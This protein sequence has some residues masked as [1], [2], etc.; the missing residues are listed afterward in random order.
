[1]NKKRLFS[2][3]VAELRDGTLDIELADAMTEVV[4]AVKE[5]GGKGSLTIKLNVAPNDSGS[6]KIDVTPTKKVPQPSLGTSIMFADNAGQL[7]RHD[8]RQ[9]N[10]FPRK[11]INGTLADP[12][13]AEAGANS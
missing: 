4:Q 9:L 3:I 5:H 12:S 13:D 2:Q 6:V 11:S 1:M 8:T 10:M 7:T